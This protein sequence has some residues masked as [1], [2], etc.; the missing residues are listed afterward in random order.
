MAPSQWVFMAI[1]LILSLG[2]SMAHRVSPGM[3][4][5]APPSPRKAVERVSVASVAPPAPE[6]AMEGVNAASV[7]PP[8]PKKAMEGAADLTDFSF[9][10]GDAVGAVGAVGS[11]II[12]GGSSMAGGG[13]LSLGRGNYPGMAG[14]D[15]RAKPGHEP[16]HRGIPGMICSG[17]S[18]YGSATAD[19]PG[20]GTPTVLKPG[21]PIPR[22]GQ[23]YSTDVP[24]GDCCFGA[25][26]GRGQGSAV[27]G[28]GS[29]DLEWANR[30][31][32]CVPLECQG[33][34]EC[35][36]A[37]I[38]NFGLIQA[39]SSMNAGRSQDPVNNSGNGPANGSQKL[40]SEPIVG[41]MVNGCAKESHE[42]ASEPIVGKMVNGCAKES[43]ELA[44]EPIVGKMV[45][46]SAKE[47]HELASEPV[48]GKK[49]EKP[50]LAQDAMAPESA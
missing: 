21:E 44:S 30:P 16:D 46:G 34:A 42:L 19:N 14:G 39:T 38:M 49:G 8:A 36:S 45:N 22:P 26:T 13:D 29:R 37:I 32:Y 3:A 40:A 7:A 33:L 41:K 50:S 43:H 12:D 23:G 18:T 15:P 27:P 24:P 5:V 28:F 20:D 47:G 9:R 48:V 11:E 1:P 4:S 31:L 35:P 2:L 10:F 25:A 6:K 17:S